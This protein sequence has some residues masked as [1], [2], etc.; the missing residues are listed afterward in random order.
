[1]CMGCVWEYG[2]CFVE[3]GSAKIFGFVDELIRGLEVELASCS[4]I[5]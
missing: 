1:M 5:C 2:L 3:Y 4:L